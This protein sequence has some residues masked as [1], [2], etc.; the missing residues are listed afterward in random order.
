MSTRADVFP[1]EYVEEL[2]K[3]Q[4]A[5]PPADA[6]SSIA[7]LERELGVPIKFFDAF[8]QTPVAAASLAQVYRATLPGGR[9]VA[10]KLQR[11]GLAELVA[12]D[13]LGFMVQIT[14]TGQTFKLRLP[15]PRAAEDRKDV[16]TLIVQMTQASLSDEEVQA[17]LQELMEK[18]QAGEAAV[19]AA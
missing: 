6:A 8:D 4:D 13:R 12:L 5:L 14:R 18:K 7:A 1:V 16:K 15:F 3:L 17:Y 10:I 19:E 2:A 9:Q 11:P